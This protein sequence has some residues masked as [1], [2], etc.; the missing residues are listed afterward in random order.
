M[1]SGALDVHLFFVKLF[2]CK[3]IEDAEPIDLSQWAACLM[4]RKA[5]PEVTLHFAH[6]PFRARE[7]L[8][9]ESDVYMIRRR[10]HDRIDGAM[11]GYVACPLAVK[12]CYITVGAPLFSPGQSW[13]PNKQRRY[14][15]FS[16]YRGA[17]EPIPGRAFEI[18]AAGEASR[19]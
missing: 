5:H 11:W 14:I 4:E 18:S 13:H 19:N 2:G 3:I 9:F 7:A 16:P 6:R 15:H 8:A 12:V 10:G 17:I 1:D